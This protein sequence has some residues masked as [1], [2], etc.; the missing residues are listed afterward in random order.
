MRTNMRGG[1]PPTLAAP[2][3]HFHATPLSPASSANHSLPAFRTVLQRHGFL[4]S[5]AVLAAAART[6]WAGRRGRKKN[7]AC[8]RAARCSYLVLSP[9]ELSFWVSSLTTV[10]MPLPPCTCLLLTAGELSFTAVS[11]QPYILLPTTYYYCLTSL[12]FSCSFTFTCLSM[13]LSS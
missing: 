4:G 7:R 13:Q 11:S 1:A 2:P 8:R 10:G 3:Q 9:D 5:F 12:G 6:G